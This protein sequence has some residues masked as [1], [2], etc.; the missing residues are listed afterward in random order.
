MARRTPYTKVEKHGQ[1]RPSHVKG[2]GDIV[3]KGFQ[4]LHSDCREFLIT[5]EDQIGPDFEIIC[6]A[7]KF[8]HI[9]GGEAKFFDYRLVWKDDLRIIEEG[10][11]TILHDDYIREAQ[12]FKHCLL[13]YALKPVEL[14]DV[15]KRR[16]SG[17]QGECRLC[18][19]IYNGI[20][21]QSRTIDQHREAAQRRRLYKRLS[22]ET[23]KI[24]SKEIYKKFKDQ[25]FNCDRSLQYTPS[26]QGEAHLDHTLPVRLLWPLHTGNATLLCSSCNNQ[27][28]DRWPSEFYGIPKL[29]ALARLTGYPYALISGPPVVNEDAIA[30]IRDDIDLFIEEWIHNPIEIRRIRR[31]IRQHTK[32][33]IFEH[34]VHIPAHLLEPDETD[35]VG[36]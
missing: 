10:E 24:D 34:A 13:C 3:F 35:A 16:H 12:R 32:V 31:I 5:R 11:F 15:H 27:K 19:T 9:A 6:P 4:C 14:F 8:A 7:C 22:G 36:D 30:E 28:H 23:G 21:N 25:C 20:K 2:M 1:H 26:G 18:K 17:R 33:D 29:K